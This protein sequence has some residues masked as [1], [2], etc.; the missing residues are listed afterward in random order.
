MVWEAR[1]AKIICLIINRHIY[2]VGVV[3]NATARMGHIRA[4]AKRAPL[5]VVETNRRSPTPQKVKRSPTAVPVTIRIRP[6]RRLSATKPVTV[7]ARI[8]QSVEKVQ[9]NIRSL[10]QTSLLPIRNRHQHLLKFHY[11][12][13]F[14]DCLFKLPNLLRNALRSDVV[15]LVVGQLNFATALTF[16]N[17]PL[18]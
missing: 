11:L 4:C 15:F 18:H 12:K 7:G 6:G 3:K 14:Y 13:L 9:R 10:R 1:E 16:I 2:T 17:R 8:T 5:P